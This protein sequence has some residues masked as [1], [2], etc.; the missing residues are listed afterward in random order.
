MNEINFIGIQFK[1]KNYIYI[2]QIQANIAIVAV[3]SVFIVI[4]KSN[5][6]MT[7]RVNTEI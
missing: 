7:W 4:F 6:T 2:Y 5:H 1:K 3:V